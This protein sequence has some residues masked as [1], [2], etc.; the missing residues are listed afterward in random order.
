MREFLVSSL[1]LAATLLIYAYAGLPG[2]VVGVALVLLFNAM[3]RRV[4]GKDIS[5]IAPEDYHDF[6]RRPYRERQRERR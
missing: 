6:P 5:E 3:Y 4:H 2:L 1:A